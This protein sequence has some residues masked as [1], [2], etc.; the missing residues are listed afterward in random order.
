[1]KLCM[2]ID[3]PIL[4]ENYGFVALLQQYIQF[5]SVHRH[6]LDRIDIRYYHW[7]NVHVQID[8]PIDVWFLLESSLLIT[9]PS[10][11]SVKLEAKTPESKSSS[12]SFIKRSMLGLSAISL[13]NH[14][15]SLESSKIAEK[16]ESSYDSESSSE[17]ELK[18]S[19]FWLIF[20]VNQNWVTEWRMRLFELIT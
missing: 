7:L 13:F 10:S 20:S 9:K 4:Y 11:F 17:E 8:F 5:Y 2:K 16:S 15:S 12:A 18:S 14:S 3:E 1:M 19:N 6:V